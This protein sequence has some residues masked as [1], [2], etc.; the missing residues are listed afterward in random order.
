MGEFDY[1]YPDEG[2]LPE[3]DEYA[4]NAMVAIEETIATQRVVTSEN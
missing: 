2:E 3:R 4:E 1:D